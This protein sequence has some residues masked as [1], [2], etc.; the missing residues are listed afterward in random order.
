M[1]MRCA[2]LVLTVNLLAAACVHAATPPAITL[3]DLTSGHAKIVDL[4]YALNP[5]NAYWPGDNYQPFQL[6][7]IAT[8]E[9]DG[10][11]SKAFSSPEHLGTHID[12][13]N[14]FGKNQVSV[15]EIK[16]EN[17]FG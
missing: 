13:P 2:S 3:D 9:K 1:I 17:L 12:A 7:T 11:L 8:L 6:H 14:H 16:P 10:V 5:K 15:D 4:G